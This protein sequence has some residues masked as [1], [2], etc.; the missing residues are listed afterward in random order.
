MPPC[1]NLRLQSEPDLLLG[2]HYCKGIWSFTTVHEVGRC[3]CL[4]V[5]VCVHASVVSHNLQHGLSLHW[6]NS[7][8]YSVAMPVPLQ[9][10]HLHIP[11]DQWHWQDYNHSNCLPQREKSLQFQYNRLRNWDRKNRL[12]WQE[13]KEDFITLKEKMSKMMLMIRMT[14]VLV[15]LTKDGSK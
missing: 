6:S 12:D 9:S 7:M 13:K 14:V 3:V 8:F 11:Q 4:R 10:Q 1:G 2:S 5:I 15:K